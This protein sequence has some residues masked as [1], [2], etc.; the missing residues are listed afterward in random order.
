MSSFAGSG[1]SVGAGAEVTGGDKRIVEKVKGVK[2]GERR[3]REGGSDL[4]SA[5]SV[6][7]A[8]SI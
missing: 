2:G 3:G 5:G 8:R 7:P 1:I 4:G 6:G